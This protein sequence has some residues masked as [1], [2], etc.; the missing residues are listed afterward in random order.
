MSAPPIRWPS[1]SAPCSARQRS[2]S[3]MAIRRGGIYGC[4]TVAD[5]WTFLRGRLEWN[6]ARPIMTVLSSRE[7]VERTEAPVILAIL[8][9][10]VAKSSAAST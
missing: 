8:E 7:Y 2:T 1:S 3:G 10:I 9:S 4:Y 5:I 6:E